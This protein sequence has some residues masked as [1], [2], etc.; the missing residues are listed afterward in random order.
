MAKSGSVTITLNSQSISNN[1]SNITVKGIIVTSGISYRGDHRTGTYTIQQGNTVIKTGSFTHGAPKNSTTTL[2]SV[3]LTVSH[4]ADGTSD[5][6]AVTYNYDSGWCTGTGSMFVKTIP[7]Q[8]TVTSAPNFNDEENPSITYSN[9]AGNVATS[10]QACIASTDGKI[11]YVPYKNIDKSKT[12]FTFELTESE[13]DVL[14]SACLNANSMKVKFYVKTVISSNTY[15]SSVQKTLSIVNAMPEVSASAEDSNSVTLAL[16][17]DKNIFVKYKSN[18][19]VAMTATAKKGAVIK[20]Y[21]IVCG[22]KS[23]NSAS[24]TINGVQSGTF[25]FS[26]TDSR[27][28]TTKVTLNK[29]LI[30]YVVPSCVIEKESVSANGSITIKIGG[31]CFNGSFGAEQNNIAVQYRYKSETDSSYSEWISASPTYDETTYT[32]IK[33]VENLDYTKRYT[34]QARIVDLIESATSSEIAIKIL[35]VFYWDDNGFFFNVPINIM[36]A[37]QDYIV[38]QGDDGIWTYR[39]WA[40]G[41]SEC[42]GKTNLEDVFC[43]A[44]NYSGFYYSDGIS[45]AFP[46]ELF[47]ENPVTCFEGGSQ[48]FVNLIRDFGSSKSSAYFIVVGHMDTT[49]NV[50]VKIQAKGRWK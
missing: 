31:N 38:E 47:I 49:A 44:N 9:P 3:T 37:N 36:G 27:G 46:S 4:R 29:T 15:Y 32:A 39:K 45:I 30:D 34:L 2:F 35:P 40:S 20:S 41:I 21:S 42:W 6:I 26:S 23:L 16:T 8:A 22:N 24:G 10:L 48:S 14:R 50:A 12:S 17:G 19:D 1:N 18:A 43:G 7:R 5:P 33:E 11:I 25:V 13:R 28:N